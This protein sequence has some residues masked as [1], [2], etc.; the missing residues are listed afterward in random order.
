ME[1]QGRRRDDADGE[2]SGDQPTADRAPRD[3]PERDES[4]RE[5]ATDAGHERERQGAD[6]ADDARG[7]GPEGGG[8]DGSERDHLEHDGDGEDPM[9]A[10][11]AEKGL[12]EDDDEE[13]DAEPGRLERASS[14]A[15]SEA[16][17]LQEGSSIP[18]FGG[19]LSVRAVL[20]IVVFL[21]I[22]MVVWLGLWTLIGGLGL[23]LGWILAAGAGFLA[24]RA[25]T[26]RSAQGAGTG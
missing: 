15:Q 23:A 17:T 22:F 3:D 2:G 19:P 6:D 25:F 21:A 8:D 18:F 12:D 9:A 1:E 10:E 7:T 16:E 26:R 4:A 5:D 20:A 13:E 11:K 14:A 24:M